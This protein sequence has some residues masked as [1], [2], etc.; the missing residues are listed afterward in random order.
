M[1]SGDCDCDCDDCNRS[2]L[3]VLDMPEMRALR[4][5]LRRAYWQY[6]VNIR[7]AI[8]QRDDLPDIVIEWIL[9]D[10]HG[11]AGHC[12]SCGKFVRVDD[13]WIEGTPTTLCRRC[14]SDALAVVDES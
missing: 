2:A 6:P 8:M 14:E 7:T 13:V 12:D 5:A 11:R 4:A 1:E 9:T 3:G 10:D